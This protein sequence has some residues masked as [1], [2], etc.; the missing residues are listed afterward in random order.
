MTIPNPDRI[1][2]AESGAATFPFSRREQLCREQAAER[3]EAL[4]NLRDLARDGAPD[5]A[6]RDAWRRAVRLGCYLSPQLRKAGRDACRREMRSRPTG[7]ADKLHPA[8]ATPPHFPQPP[9][10]RLAQLLAVAELDQA[11]ALQRLREAL[12]AGDLRRIARAAELTRR[13]GVSDPDLPWEIVEN[14]EALVQ[15]EGELRAALRAEDVT[16]A[17]AAWFRADSVWPNCLDEDDD[18]AGRLM[19]R[20]WGHTMRRSAPRLFGR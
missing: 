13:L 20:A 2:A 1:E 3:A 6:V 12:A 7:I 17:A 5:E 18:H 14:A 11:R 10:P 16:G 9:S 8:D 4:A 19:F 15:V